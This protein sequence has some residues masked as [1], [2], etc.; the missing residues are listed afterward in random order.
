MGNRMLRESLLE[1][2]KISALSDFD[3]RL[4]IALILLAD[5]YGVVDARPAII[6]GRGF[7]LRERVTT[8]DIAEGLRRL[9]AGRCV[10]PY[11]VGGRPY[12]QFLNWS[13][14]QRVR[15]SKH[16]FPTIEESDA[17]I[18]GELP[19]VAAS[20]GESRPEQEPEVEVEPEHRT[21]TPRTGAECD[22]FADFWSVYP[23][24]V[25]KTAANAAWKSGKCEKI[26]DTIIADVQRRCETE[27]KG[28]DMHYIPHPT[29]YLHQRRWEDETAPT[30]RKDGMGREQPR[31]NAALDYEQ[32]EY[33]N[34]DFG[35]DFFIDLEKYGEE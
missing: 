9:T 29:T 12:V 7:P 5:D 30:E 15:D 22:R 16:K 14:H 13:D 28:Q 33:K 20:C 21:R 3:F 6:K 26:A 25:K 2:D 23:N 27:W 8:K 18:R 17:E 10:A 1:S 4:W 34:E 35:D 11:T 19:Q 32:R 31:S 24:K